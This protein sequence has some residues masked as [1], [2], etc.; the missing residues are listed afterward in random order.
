MKNSQTLSFTERIIAA[1]PRLY[2]YAAALTPDLDAAGE[3]L[4]EANRVMLESESQYDPERDFLSWACG[5]LRYRVLARVRDR[6][7]ERLCFDSELVETLAQ[8]MAKREADGD[9]RSTWLRKCHE[10]L[11]EHQRMMLDL[12]YES[13]ATVESMSKLLNRPVTSVSSSL[14]KIRRKLSDC[15]SQLQNVIP[16]E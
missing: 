2:S 14:T 15:V 6:G 10:K 11:T 8:Q 13:G 4:Q 7:R 3:V 5:V 9:L 16:V 12:R 1:Q